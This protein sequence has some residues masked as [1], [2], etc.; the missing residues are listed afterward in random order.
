MNPNYLQGKQR[1]VYEIFCMTCS[2]DGQG[3]QILSG[4]VA[5]PRHW[6]EMPGPP[7]LLMV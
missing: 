3:M 6:G 4:E 7:L 1:V 2:P 5:S